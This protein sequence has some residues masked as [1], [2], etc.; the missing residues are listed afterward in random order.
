MNAD[1]SDPR[2]LTDARQADVE[3]VWSPDGTRIAFTRVSPGRSSIWLMNADG[4]HARRLTSDQRDA[5]AY[6]PAFSPDGHRIAFTGITYD[7][8]GAENADVWLIGADGRGLQRLTFS[9]SYDADPAFSPDGRQIAFATGRDGNGEIYTMDVEGHDQRRLTI[10]PG[11]DTTP[12][13]SPDGSR[14]V[15][16]SNRRGGA[17]DLWMMDADGSGQ[18]CLT[19][20]AAGDT[21]PSWTGAGPAH[22]SA[23]ATNARALPALAPPAG[24]L[25]PDPDSTLQT[26][27]VGHGNG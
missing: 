23:P 10:D 26:L 13:Y 7:A 9:P 24:C 14:V 20:D 2:P 16:T 8:I 11:L 22:Q 18:T 27:P 17:G 3:P 19:T 5:V 4:S 6:R 25:E 12:A 1:G 15:F 21:E